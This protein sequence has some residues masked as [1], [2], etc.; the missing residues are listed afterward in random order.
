V[1]NSRTAREMLIK[2][3]EEFSMEKVIEKALRQDVGP[4]PTLA[5]NK[6][7]YKYVDNSNPSFPTW[8]YKKKYRDRDPVLNSEAY[9]YDYKM[10]ERRQRQ[11]NFDCKLYLV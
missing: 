8:E 6:E 2:P 3:G 7:N 4:D 10:I 5:M 1:K 11:F 9:F